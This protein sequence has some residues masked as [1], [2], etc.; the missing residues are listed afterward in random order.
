GAVAA[1]PRAPD[2]PQRRLWQRRSGPPAPPG[3]RRRSRRSAPRRRR[4][5]ER[6]WPARR[7]S[8]SAARPRGARGRRACSQ[9]LLL[10]EE[11]EDLLRPRPVVLD[12]LRLAARRRLAERVDLGARA[13]LA[14]ALPLNPEVGERH[15]LLRLLLRAHDPLH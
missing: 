3:P 10:Q 5:A 7:A 2:R 4:R 13:A 12:S 8:P 14:R 11:L 1:A 6:P 9:R 15:R